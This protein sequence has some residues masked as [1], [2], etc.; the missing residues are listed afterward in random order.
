MTSMAFIFTP[1]EPIK[2]TKFNY[3]KFI[4]YV[5][6]NSTLSSLLFI[7]EW[8]K[9]WITKLQKEDATIKEYI[10]EYSHTNP[11]LMRAKQ[12]PEQ[13]QDRNEMFLFVYR[14][15]HGEDFNFHFDI[16]KVNDF[17]SSKKPSKFTLESNGFYI[18]PDTNYDNV[19]LQDHRLPYFTQMFT[20]DKPYIIIDGNKRVMA[21]LEKG[22][23]RFEGYEITP[24]IASQC[25][26]TEL[27]KWFY[28][29]LYEV[30]LFS[31]LIYEGKTSE[32]IKRNSNAF[33]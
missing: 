5:V 2:Y 14:S 32:E 27:E 20:I 10:K 17:I 6:G 3:E 30:N 24:D 21:R 23:E 26:F 9:F 7:D 19:N 16:E 22:I 11:L 25:F 4:D 28:A 1:S 18:D 15:G 31:I 13:F 8:K 12:F 33:N 29:L